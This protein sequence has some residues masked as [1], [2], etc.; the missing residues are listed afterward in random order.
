MDGAIDRL[1]VRPKHFRFDDGAWSADGGYF[2]YSAVDESIGASYLYLWQPES[3]VPFLV[4]ATA[5]QSP[6]SEFVWLADGDGFYF[7]LDDQG[8]WFYAVT[9]G[10]VTDLNHD[11]PFNFPGN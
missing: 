10:Q 6:F 9:I 8:L 4:Q 1:F 3:G 2:V 11:P 5:S 7:N